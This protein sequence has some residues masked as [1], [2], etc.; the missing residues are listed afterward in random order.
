MAARVGVFTIWVVAA[1]AT[2]L[3]LI[4]SSGVAAQSC[5]PHDSGPTDDIEPEVCVPALA[6]GGGRDPLGFCQVRAGR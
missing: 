1:I 4:P 5:H 6:R 3:L 2:P